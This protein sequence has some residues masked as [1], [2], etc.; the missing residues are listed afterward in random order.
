LQRYVKNKYNIEVINPFQFSAKKIECP[1][2]TIQP[3]NLVPKIQ[4]E[5]DE[6]VCNNSVSKI[7]SSL[8]ESDACYDGEILTLNQKIVNKNLNFKIKVSINGL[9]PVDA[10]IDSD[11]HL[12]LISLEYFL[13]IRDKCDIN[14]LNEAPTVFNGIG[15]NVVS[16]FPPFLAEIQIGRVLT[17]VKFI[18]TNHLSTSPCLL[19]TDFIFSHEVS[20]LKNNNGY[21]LIIGDLTNKKSEVP[22]I[23]SHKI[24]NT[25]PNLH[26]VPNHENL[27][28]GSCPE[29]S[30]L[31][32]ENFGRR[33]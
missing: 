10:E 20:L 21:S 23:I 9:K 3:D 4:E 25:T 8:A 22:V 11:S 28:P 19:G 26:T 16:D 2:C 29:I 15:S 33:F 30:P 14:F 17:Q 1:S 32:E 18:V 7:F 31:P 27:V 5:V 12:S 13:S 6:V 24:I